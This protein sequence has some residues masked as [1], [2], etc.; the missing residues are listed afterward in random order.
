MNLYFLVCSNEHSLVGPLYKHFCSKQYNPLP[1]LVQK[2]FG[3]V[4]PVFIYLNYIKMA[5]I[6][7]NLGQSPFG[8]EYRHDLY[9]NLTVLSR[10][11][12]VRSLSQQAVNNSLGKLFQGARLRFVQSTNTHYFP[13]NMKPCRDT[14]L[15]PMLRLLMPF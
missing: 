9:L 14:K 13:T 8:V 3:Y 6:Q 12:L 4:K 5:L 2:S 15:C 10:T 11:P 1:K 7:S